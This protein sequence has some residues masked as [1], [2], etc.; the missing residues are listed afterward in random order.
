[1]EFLELIDEWRGIRDKQVKPRTALLRERR[2]N[3]YLAPA[4]QGWQVKNITA[5]KILDVI[6]TISTSSGIDVAHRL[7]SDINGALDYAAVLGIIN[8]NPAARLYR[9]LP[10]KSK[11]HWG[12]LSPR[13]FGQLLRKIDASTR[14]T[15]TVRNA[16]WALIYTAG[17][18]QEIVHGRWD[19]ID[20]GTRKWVI[21]KE[22]MKMGA[23]HTLPITHPL[24]A[25]LEEQ[26]ELGTSWIF[27]SPHGKRGDTPIHLSVV[28]SLLSRIR[29]DMCQTVHGIRHV[30]STRAND[31]G[32]WASQVIERQL[33][34]RPRGVAAIY[35]HSSMLDERRRLMDWW[36]DQVMQWRGLV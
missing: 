11:E 24:L 18:R 32:L 27:P 34:H 7:L 9:Y 3:R 4:L 21:P 35:D 26:R 10:P 8:Y 28:N 19:E 5:K 22:R 36:A 13:D 17:R 31:S 16:W 33:D 23:P 20:W 6:T 1:M 25:I 29:G 30:F 14:G 2:I 15:K 12:Y